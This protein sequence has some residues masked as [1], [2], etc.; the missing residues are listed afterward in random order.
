VEAIINTAKCVAETESIDRAI[1][2]LQ[3]EL[4]QSTGARAE[5]LAAIAEFHIQKGA[6]DQAQGSVNQAM[7]ANP[8]YAYPWKLQAQIFMN[9]EGIDK[10]ALDSALFAYKS[11]SERNPSDPSGY[12]ERYKIFIKKTEFEKA[13]DE[14]NKIYTI[15]PKYPNLHFYLGALLSVQGNHKDAAE[16]FRREL[17][18]NPNVP[19]TMIALG[20]EYLELGYFQNALELFSKAMQLEPQNPDAKQN[21]GW[22]NYKLKNFQAAVTLIRAA[23]AADKANPLLYRRLGIVQRDM[24]DP[25]GAC[26]SFRKYLEMEPDA[27]DKAE[28][29]ACL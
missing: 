11:Y 13:K 3:D 25:A 2:M 28:F 4:K 15:Y 27:S 6:W 26:V 12:L 14:L 22:A 17:L 10:T 7:Q 21:T 8:D 19:K 9:R 5:F 18:N 20:K 23:L 24:G 29:Q 16:E 1:S